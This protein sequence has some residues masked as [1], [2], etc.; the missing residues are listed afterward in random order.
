M[1]L[2]QNEIPPHDTGQNLKINV[3]IYIIT[4]YFAIIGIHYLP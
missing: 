3:S 4:N 1:F 2:L